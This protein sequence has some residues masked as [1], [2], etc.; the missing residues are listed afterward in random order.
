M[1]TSSILVAEVRK[2]PDISQT[3]RKSDTG[4]EKVDLGG[5][6]LTCIWLVT[7]GAILVHLPALL[8][9]RHRWL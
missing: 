8:F 6:R 7:A 5:P 9:L 1:R 4:Q 3:D 2:S